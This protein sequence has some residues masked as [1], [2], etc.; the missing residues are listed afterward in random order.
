MFQYTLNIS[1][2]KNIKLND[3]CQLFRFIYGKIS[4][5]DTFL[6]CY[7]YKIIFFNKSKNQYF[8]SF[9]KHVEELRFIKN[10]SYILKEKNWIM[11]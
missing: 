11:K 3:Y 8:L 2:N 6:F 10:K 5:I 4:L 9:L 1:I 7:D